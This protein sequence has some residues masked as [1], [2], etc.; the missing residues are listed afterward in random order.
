MT[1]SIVTPERSGDGAD[2]ISWPNVIEAESR[3]NP[4]LQIPSSPMDSRFITTPFAYFSWFSEI[5][6]A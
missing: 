4:A 5:E 2:D 6:L 1:S 3:K